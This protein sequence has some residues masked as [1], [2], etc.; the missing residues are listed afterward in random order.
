MLIEGHGRA[1]PNP[2]TVDKFIGDCIMA[3]WGAPLPVPR[4]GATAV[5]ALIEILARPAGWATRAGLRGNGV[6]VQRRTGAPQGG[7]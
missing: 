2:R 7:E 3:M 4:A 1:P 5:E 6:V